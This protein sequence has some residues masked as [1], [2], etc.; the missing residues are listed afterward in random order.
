[1][2]RELEQAERAN[3]EVSVQIRLETFNEALRMSGVDDP[4]RR[5][6][7]VEN[8]RVAI[9]PTMSPPEIN[10]RSRALLNT[11]EIVGCEKQ[12]AI[13]IDGESIESKLNRLR[14]RM[15]GGDDACRDDLGG[16][17]GAAH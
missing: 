14:D 1:M 7:A 12:S 13:T 17:A 11:I 16:G 8:Y 5:L 9:D 15:D 10:A 2:G 4:V 6:V 3:R